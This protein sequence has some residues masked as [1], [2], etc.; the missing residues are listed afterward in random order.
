MFCSRQTDS[1]CAFPSLPC[2]VHRHHPRRR[3]WASAWWQ[4]PPHPPAAHSAPRTTDTGHEPEHP[5]EATGCR[6]RRLC[7]IPRPPSHL[8]PSSHTWQTATSTHSVHRTRSCPSLHLRHRP[9]NPQTTSW[10]LSVDPQAQPSFHLGYSSHLHRPATWPP[11]VCRTHGSHLPVRLSQTASGSSCRARTQE[12]SSASIHPPPSC[13]L[14][15]SSAPQST[16]R[17]PR[18]ASLRRPGRA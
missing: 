4:Q 3:T 8:R 16:H 18:P 13:A 10:R 5:K 2:P 14:T 15:C 6:S 7:S 11:P 9:P 1:V 12:Q 17:Q